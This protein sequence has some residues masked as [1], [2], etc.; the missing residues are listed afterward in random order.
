MAIACD[1]T[2][3]SATERERY[4]QL[5]ERLIG[6][7]SAVVETPVGFTL[8]VSDSLPPGDIAEWLMLERR[9][10]PFFSFSIECAGERGPVWLSVTGGAGIKPFIRAEFGLDDVH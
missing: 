9:C 7:V 8:T 3:F 1:M 4:R 5:R 10:C 2:A 6:V